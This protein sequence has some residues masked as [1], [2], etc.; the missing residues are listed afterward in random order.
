MFEAMLDWPCLLYYQAC[1]EA[2]A[3]P[4]RR[5]L[6]VEPWLVVLQAIVVVVPWLVVL[7]AI[8]VVV[9]WMVVCRVVETVPAVPP[10]EPVLAELAETEV[11]VL[12]EIGAAAL[13]LVH[14]LVALSAAHLASVPVAE[15]MEVL[16][17]IA[18]DHHHAVCDRD[19]LPQVASGTYHHAHDFFSVSP[20]SGFSLPRLYSAS[21]RDRHV[22]GICL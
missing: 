3:A 12:V 20:S 21:G 18:V 16:G 15:L 17:W 19:H 14:L 5:H 1:S 13:G 7:Q 10:A 8:V 9:T 22:R 4:F 6:E 11:V 2:W